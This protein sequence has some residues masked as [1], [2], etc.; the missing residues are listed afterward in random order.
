[1]YTIRLRNDEL[2]D[3]LVMDLKS[4]GIEASVHF[5]PPL[6]QM[7][8]YKKT[9]YIRTGLDGTETVSRS[10][11]TLPMYPKLEQQE[12]EFICENI[13]SYLSDRS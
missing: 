3:S 7:E 6:H 5:D 4:K 9:E 12:I 1:M 13:L 11:V 10:I 8:P 2:R